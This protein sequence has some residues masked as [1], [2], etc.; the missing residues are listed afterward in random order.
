M[1][2]RIVSLCDPE[3][4]ILFGS[5]AR[6]TAGPYSDVDFLVG[7]PLHSTKRED[8]RKIRR[9]LSGM[10][11]S[12]NVVVVPPQEMDRFQQCIG[13]IVRAAAQERKTLYE[14]VA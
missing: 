12:K 14:C 13:P 11:R 8:R 7:M 6:G 5:Y 1:V 3:R 2:R 9:A 4:I 10:G